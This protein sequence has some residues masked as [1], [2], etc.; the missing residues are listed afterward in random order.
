MPWEEKNVLYRGV[1]RVRLVQVLFACGHVQS[2][3][4]VPPL[5][6]LDDRPYPPPRAR[7]LGGEKPDIKCGGVHPRYRR[8]GS[9]LP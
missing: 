8:L 9:T 6:S 7:A 2:L 1:W 5:L 3:E 4:Q